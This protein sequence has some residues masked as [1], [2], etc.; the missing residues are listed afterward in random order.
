MRYEL[1]VVAMLMAG[2][3]TSNEVRIPAHHA[4]RPQAY[5]DGYVDGCGSGQGKTTQSKD[6]ER[7]KKESLYANGWYDGYEECK[8]NQRSPIRDATKK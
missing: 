4:D 3:A 2:C 5:R 6:V 7:I 8:A 1:L